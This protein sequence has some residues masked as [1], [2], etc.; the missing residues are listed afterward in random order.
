MYVQYSFFDKEIWS[1][2]ATLNTCIPLILFIIFR[3]TLDIQTL[4]LSS[5]IGMMRGNLLSKIIFT[6]FLSLLSFQNKLDIKRLFISIISIIIIHYIP[7]NNF[8]QLKIY[9]NK[10]LLFL[11]RITIFL[12]IFYFMY[13]IIITINS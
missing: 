2:Y 13:K 3:Q 11:F 7:Y 12:W 10:Y 9:N 5:L 4:T 1:I 8:I 6:T